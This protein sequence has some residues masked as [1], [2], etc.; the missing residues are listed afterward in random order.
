MSDCCSVNGKSRTVPAVMACP[1]NGARSRHVDL[2]T[3]RS[4]VRQLALGMPNTEYYFCEAA[5]CDV[6]YFP[7]DRQAASFRRSDLLVRVGIKE[8]LDPIPVCYC[9]D[10][11][12]KDIVDEIAV[13]GRSTVAERITK[14]VKAGNCACEVKNPSGKCCLGH[15]TRV[16]Q[17]CLRAVRE[18]RAKVAR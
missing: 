13:K 14:E 11:T 6:V 18:G 16:T 10:F 7:L 5:D 9:F 8:S 3:V 1:V 2:L 4:L 17:D 12:R 15:V